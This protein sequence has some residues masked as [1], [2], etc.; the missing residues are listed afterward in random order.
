MHIARQLR[1]RIHRE[2]GLTASVGIGATKT[3]AKIA[4]TRSKPDGL[5]LVRAEDTVAFMAELPVGALWG[6]GRR[7]E[8]T[9]Q[10]S[11]IRTVGRSHSARR[12]SW[13]ASSARL[14]VRT[15]MR[16]P[17]AWIPAR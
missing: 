5:L 17:T 1:A 6:V 12:S 2:T 9:L 3:V 13:P 8:E 7:T 15:C 14:R 10:R 16:W 11:G 4:S